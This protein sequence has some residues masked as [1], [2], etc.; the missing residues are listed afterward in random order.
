M[1]HSRTEANFKQKAIHRG[2]SLHLKTTE[3][4]RIRQRCKSKSKMANKIDPN[5]NN[6]VQQCNTLEEKLK[7]AQTPSMSSNRRTQILMKK[8]S[9]NKITLGLN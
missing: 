8:L 4:S 3:S 5:V 1:S 6:F 9:K 7:I 2:S